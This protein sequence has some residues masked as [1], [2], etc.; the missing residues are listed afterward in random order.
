MAKRWTEKEREAWAGFIMGGGMF[1]PSDRTMSAVV[2]R[3]RGREAR[4]GCF[5]EPDLLPWVDGIA[6]GA[7]H[8][9]SI[10][11]LDHL[12]HLPHR[13]ANQLKN[14]VD[15]VVR[16]AI[17]DLSVFFSEPPTTTKTGPDG[18]KLKPPPSPLEILNSI[19]DED[20]HRA[21]LATRAAIREANASEKTAQGIAA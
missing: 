1:P 20:V 19:P 3:L 10:A 6:K 21:I 12:R 17:G 18:E 7:L 9:A 16:V 15:V 11:A 2:E 8:R 14:Y 13:Q 4:D 5:A